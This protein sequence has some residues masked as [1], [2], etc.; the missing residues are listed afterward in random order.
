M[1]SIIKGNTEYVINFTIN[2]SLN[3]NNLLF[4]SYQKTLINIARFAQGDK[5]IFWVWTKLFEN[6]SPIMTH[7]YIEFIGILAN[8]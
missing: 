8:S 7:N 2:M 4:F 6:Q 5:N 3:R 1:V